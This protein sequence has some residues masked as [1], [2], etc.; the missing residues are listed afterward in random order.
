VAV[1]SGEPEIG[2]D[3]LTSVLPLIESGKLR[4]LAVSSAT[5]SVSLP[6]VPTFEEQGIKNFDVNAWFALIGPP[7][8][9]PVIAEK[10]EKAIADLK[11]NTA[12][13]TTLRSMATSL[14]L[15]DGKALKKLVE[16]E[17]QRWPSIVKDAGVKLE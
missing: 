13:T 11:T 3:N 7:G 4:A 5:R 17:R 1:L 8:M 2:F 15:T 6:A 12:F 14:E 9:D 16:L 10:L